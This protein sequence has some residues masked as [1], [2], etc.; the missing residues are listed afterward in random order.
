MSRL[1]LLSTALIL[2]AGT[3]RSQSAAS[4]TGVW[5]GNIMGLKLIFHFT[6]SASG[7]PGPC[8]SPPGRRHPTHLSR[9]TATASNTTI[10]KGPYTSPPPSPTPIKA[11]PSRPRS[12]S[13]AAASRTATK[14]SSAITPLP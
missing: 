3:S 5:T 1:L 8:R 6:V 10:P 9:I 11:V 4:F 13:P 7:Q 2:I 14:P 12:S